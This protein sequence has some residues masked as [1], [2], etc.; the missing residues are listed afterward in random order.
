MANIRKMELDTSALWSWTIPLWGLF[1]LVLFL[2]GVLRAPVILQGLPD[3]VGG[4]IKKHV[5][6]APGTR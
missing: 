1:V 3:Q 4:A 2:G 6:W 5:R